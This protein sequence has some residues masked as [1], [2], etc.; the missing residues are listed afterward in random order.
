MIWIGLTGGIATGKSTVSGILRK[1]GYAVIDADE[2]AKAVVQPGTEAHAEIVLAFGREAIDSRGELNRQK[3]GEIVFAD[4]A[5]L[6]LLESIIHPRVRALATEKKLEL[7]AS[8]QKLAFYDVPL[9]FEKK[10]EPLFDR[11]VVV[12]CRPETQL[13]RLM[14]R[15][16]F[17][18]A[19][20]R[21]RIAAQLPIQDKVALAHDV[22]DNEGSLVELEV[23]VKRLVARLEA[24]VG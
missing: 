9:L 1:L 20:A 18:E 7:S 22:V 12:A 21:R 8:G 14:A 5:K 15:N 11:I 17:A 23:A 24:A 16:G 19:E 10:M 6:S 2:L 4:P 13:S 3:I